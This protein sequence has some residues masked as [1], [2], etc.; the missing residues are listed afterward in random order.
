MAKHRKR[1]KKK[2]QKG[3]IKDYASSEKFILRNVDDYE[4]PDPAK[5]IR[6]IMSL[7]MN[8]HDG[9]TQREFLKM[10]QR[11]VF[12][13]AFQHQ[14]RGLELADLIQEGYIGLL[15]A[16]EKFDPDRGNRFSTL[17]WWW[18]Q[19]AIDRAIKNKASMIRV[20]IYKLEDIGSVQAEWSK[21]ITNEHKRL[22]SAELSQR[23]GIPRE[24]VEKYKIWTAEHDSLDRE[25]SG[26][27]EE[28][29]LGDFVSDGR[30]L[31]EEE[32]ARK[33]DAEYIRY[34]VEQ[35]PDKERAFLKRKFGFKDKC[36]RTRKEM[37]EIYRKSE[38]QIYQQERKILERIRQNFDI[39]K[40]NNPPSAQLPTPKETKK[41][42]NKR[43]PA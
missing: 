42:G 21:G 35:L 22:S 4:K 18:I 2:R 20:P 36:T 13:F 29:T 16:A 41:S 17:A 12:R 31:P 40:V 24:E 10:F 38:Q 30:I 33:M 14:H 28:W 39:D 6:V 3:I 7:R 15:R 32:V 25:L 11:L 8:P 37:A 19:E 9:K 5:E 43:K 34:L 23:T 26:Q 27:A 1:R